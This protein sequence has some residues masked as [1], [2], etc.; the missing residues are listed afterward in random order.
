[1]SGLQRTLDM[2]EIDEE[3]FLAYKDRLIDYLERFVSE[4]VVKAFDIEA[5]L[6][7]LE[8]AGPAGWTSCCGSPPSVRRPTSRPATIDGERPRAAAARAWRTP[9]QQPQLAEWRA[10]WS[11]LASWFVTADRQHPSQ[12]NCCAAVPGKPSPTCSRP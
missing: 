7:R 1:M 6:R 3:A 12:A 10:R 5:M 8:T 4:L 11:G 9:N 2:Q